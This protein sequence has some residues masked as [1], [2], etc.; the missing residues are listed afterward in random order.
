MLAIGSAQFGMNYGATN[1]EGQVGFDEIQRI[2]D[3]C[4]SNGISKIDT[5]Q[6]YGES[7]KVLGLAVKQKNFFKYIS[8]LKPGISE[9]IGI[10]QM[11]QEALFES[12]HNLKTDHLYAMMV[13]DS[14]DLIGNKG[15]EVFE[16]MRELKIKGLV[17]KIGV[18]LYSTDELKQIIEK[19]DIDIVQLPMNL[20][21][22]R[23]KDEGLLTKLDILGVEIHFRSIFLQGI[24][25]AS[26]EKLPIYFSPIMRHLCKIK[27]Y[28]I[29][30][31]ISNIDCCLSPFKSFI[32]KEHTIVAGVT[33][34]HQISEIINSWNKCKN[35]EIPDFTINNEKYYNPSL[36]KI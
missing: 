32:S 24:L 36:W 25:L 16:S 12:L 5:A 8:K 28:C 1:Q 21:D 20:L 15:E 11:I 14:R 18:S 33:S 10:N 6:A 13:H 3:F 9:N 23:F 2:I 17:K 34:I 27:D 29:N 7:E 19:F 30:E 35:I 31:G 4:F 26:P 22:M